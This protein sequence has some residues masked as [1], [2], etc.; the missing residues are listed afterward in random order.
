MPM[1]TPEEEPRAIAAKAGATKQTNKAV[2]W[3]KLGVA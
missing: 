2:G 3:V 1:K